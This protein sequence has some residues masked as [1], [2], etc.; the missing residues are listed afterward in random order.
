MSEKTLHGLTCN[1]CSGMVPIPEGQVIVT[2]P[3]CEMRSLVKGERGVRR[4]QVPRAISRQQAEKAMQGF[5]SGKMQIA[6]NA[7]KTSK[8]QETFLAY[9]PFWVKWAHVMGWVFGEERVKR[10]E[11]TTYE[12]RE[13]KIAEEMTWNGVALDVGEFGV[14]QIALENRV[15]EAF[16][17]DE[18]HA[19]GMVFE[20]VNSQSDADEAAQSDFNSRVRKMAD[21]DRVSQTFIRFAKERL[22][23]VYYPLWVVRYLYRGRAYQVVVDAHDGKV[24]YGKAPGSTLFRAVALV[25]GMA[26]GALLAVDG[27]S[28]SAYMA[29]ASGDEDALVFFGI[30]ALAALGGGFG[31]MYAGYR[32]FRYGEL[33]EYRANTKS[34]R[35]FRSRSEK[36]VRRIKEVSR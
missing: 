6:R 26:V 8:I 19:T 16:N 13:I 22:G 1:N 36:G 21:L 24:L 12:P 15:L 32:A 18:L 23:L 27:S 2:C 25:G 17:A 4:Y 35:R 34:K 33:Y 10:G 20:P 29:F 3:Y 11:D 7:A 30:A 5:L 28:F 31:M 9:L 14:E